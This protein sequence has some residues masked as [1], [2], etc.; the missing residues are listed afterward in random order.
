[1]LIEMYGQNFGCF[2]DE[3]R[4]SLVT[5]RRQSEGDDGIVRVPVGGDEESLCLLRCVA[6]YGANASGKS[7]VLR[8][9][10]AL[11]T[12]LNLSAGFPSDLPL[13][14][15]HNPFRLRERVNQ[16]VRLGA[17][18]VVD[19]SV[20]DYNIGF[21]PKEFVRETLAE[22]G[23]NGGR[24]VLFDRVGQRVEGAWTREPHFKLLAE[25][26]RPNGLLLALADR[27]APRLAKGIA[28][29]FRRALSVIS[30]QVFGGPRLG[31]DVTGQLAKAQPK[32]ATW[33]A[34]RL[35][36]ADTGILAV[37]VEEQKRTP[38]AEV[39]EQLRNVRFPSE[40]KLR[41]HHVGEAKVQ[42]FGFHQESSGTQ[43]L[44]ELAPSLYGLESGGPPTTCWIDEVDASLHPELLRSLVQRF[45]RVLDSSHVWGQMILTTHETALIDGPA[46]HAALLR[47]QV[48]FTEKGA[49]GA[50]RLY[51]LAEF[52]ERNVHNIRRRYLEGRYG[53]L[54]SIVRSED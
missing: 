23:A 11:G 1:M 48:Y 8:A 27:L 54:P 13:V 22:I 17:K 37:D 53:G 15:A 46:K 16:E 29:G 35:R 2:R 52:K 47:D 36:E 40:Y 42:A 9:A 49:D 41:L 39:A 50:A 19:R 44:I 24:S 4:L 26:F 31:E 51:S 14:F 3:F 28:A 6:I 7:T 21:V 34:S 18:V 5:N 33:L 32:F 38:P 30:Q 43:R 10:D 20:L 25:S 45:N 12:M